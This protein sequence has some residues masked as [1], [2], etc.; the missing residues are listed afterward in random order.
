MSPLRQ[1]S[2]VVQGIEIDFSTDNKLSSL[3]SYY[4]HPFYE[5]ENSWDVKSIRFK[6]RLVKEPP[7]V[8]ANS[9]KAI[10][11]P[12]V[13]IYDNRGKIYFSSKS[14][15]VICLDPIKRKAE[16]FFKNETLRNSE[17]SFSLLG[18]SIIEVLKYY[19]LYFLHAAALYV[20][21]VAYL[22][23]GDSGSGKTTT[24][25]SLVREGFQYVSDDSLFLSDSKGEITVSPMYQY[26]HVDED[27]SKHFPEISGGKA[28]KIPEGTKVPID[29]SRFYPGSF[30]PVLRPDVI[31]FP[32]I[33]SEERSML[34][35][36]SQ[37][38]SYKKLLKQTS[39]PA[40]KNISRDQLR[41][42]EKLVKQ[43]KGFELLSGR[44]IYE[45]SKLLI[46]L[47]SKVNY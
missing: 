18:A 40:D 2:Y 43:T 8:P 9:V 16:G 45:D 30:I 44:D 34:N 6:L 14:G 7:S 36:L 46:G 10:N 3:I 47:L 25:L 15:S 23:T 38:E 1:S 4:F 28:P 17:E 21:K 35:P 42:L 37:T 20:N 29:I 26:F 5:G 31:I 39:L 12:A 22:I 27:L 33:I 19:G 13:T 11:S 41:I 32:K 24:S